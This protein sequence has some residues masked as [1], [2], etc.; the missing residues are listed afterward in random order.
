MLDVRRHRAHYYVIVI[1][2]DESDHKLLCGISNAMAKTNEAS[3]Y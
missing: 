1:N 3:S 2:C